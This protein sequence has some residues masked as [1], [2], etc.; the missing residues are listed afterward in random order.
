MSL[1]LLSRSELTPTSVGVAL[2]SESRRGKMLIYERPTS[3]AKCRISRFSRF[4]RN[5]VVSKIF[6]KSIFRRSSN[7]LTHKTVAPSYYAVHFY[8]RHCLFPFVFLAF[9]L[10]ACV[11]TS[12]W[13]GHDSPQPTCLSRCVL[14][15][16]F[17]AA[18]N[19][20]RI[21]R[22]STVI[23][24]HQLFFYYCL[25]LFSSCVFIRASFSSVFRLS[26]S[27]SLDPN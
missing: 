24:Q 21:S 1:F 27:I 9:L 8:C 16:Y 2:G 5:T 18:S 15:V 7:Y 25:I 26:N 13:F 10:F 11:V 19:F 20:L 3:S 6:E 17:S 12:C 22:L 4:F 14:A 23:R